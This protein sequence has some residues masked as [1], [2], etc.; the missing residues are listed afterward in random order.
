MERLIHVLI[1]QLV[2][3]TASAVEINLPATTAMLQSIDSA[4]NEA[5]NKSKIPGGVI[6]LEKE[7]KKYQGIYGKISYE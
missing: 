1:F 6:W 5:V 2:I 7:N 4:I 3:A